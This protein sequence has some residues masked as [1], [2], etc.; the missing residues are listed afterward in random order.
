MLYPHIEDNAIVVPGLVRL[1]ALLRLTQYGWP[2][3][4]SL[5][6]LFCFLRL[7]PLT[8]SCLQR[9]PPTCE[10]ATSPKLNPATTE[11]MTEKRRKNENENEKKK[12]KKE[13]M[14]DAHELKKSQND[15][16]LSRTF[17]SRMCITGPNKAV[18]H[19]QCILLHRPFVMWSSPEGRKTQG[20]LF[21]PKDENTKGRMTY[22]AIVAPF[23][24]PGISTALLA[25]KSKRRERS[26]RR[27][28]N[29]CPISCGN[30]RHCTAKHKCKHQ[31]YTFCKQ[32]DKA[33]K[34]IIIKC[35]FVLLFVF[36]SSLWIFVRTV[37]ILHPPSSL[38]LRRSA[39]GAKRRP[40]CPP[41]PPSVPCVGTKR[42]I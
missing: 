18:D 17:P 42:L 5:L 13:C 6:P 22:R 39:L 19:W 35:V 34:K 23:L 41:P 33:T 26:V 24:P 4:T 16:F 2:V 15:Q 25:W 31:R 30:V 7:G 32:A 20:G 12:K 29:I 21:S 9:Q 8:D 10:S 14:P 38:R 1:P 40:L 3:G 11:T 36:D 28:N 37:S 27:G